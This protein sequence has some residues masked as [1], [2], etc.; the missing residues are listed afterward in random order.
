M[1]RKQNKVVVFKKL[2]VR[3]ISEADRVAHNRRREPPKPNLLEVLTDADY[4]RTSLWSVAHLM[5]SLVEVTSERLS[6]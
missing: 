3:N 4:S 2:P 1:R 6:L 5:K